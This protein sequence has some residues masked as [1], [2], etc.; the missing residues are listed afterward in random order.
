MAN[1]QETQETQT[2]TPPTDTSLVNERTTDD[3][4]K[5]PE[6]ETDKAK[7]EGIEFTPLTAEDLKFP[8]GMQVDNAARDDF[9]G[10]LNNR[11]MTPAQQAQALVDLQAKVAM[12]ASEAG[13]QAWTT[14]QETWVK[15]VK[16]DPDIGGAKLEPALASIGKLIEQHGSPELRAVMDLTGAGNNVHVIKFLSNISKAL[17]EGGH[18]SGT[19][20]A[21]EQSVADLLYPTMKKGS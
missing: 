16:A 9:L 1:E 12:Q 7:T 3:E 10:I 6:N 5:T 14:L 19:P 18:V 17:T 21:T 8:E 2:T 20:G 13:S 15:D 11:E 4:N